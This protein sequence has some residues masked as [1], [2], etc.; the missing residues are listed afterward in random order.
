M[1]SKVLSGE[2]YFQLMNTYT[3]ET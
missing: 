2:I 3:K 1:D